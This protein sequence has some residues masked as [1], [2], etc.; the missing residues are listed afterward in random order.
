MSRLRDFNAKLQP[1]AAVP[2]DREEALMSV[3]DNIWDKLLRDAP[4]LTGLSKYWFQAGIL[5]A[6]TEMERT[7]ADGSPLFRTRQ[8]L[9]EHLRTIDRP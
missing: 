1:W 2:P 8:Q 5:R 9:I 6:I 7:A 3:P 4:K